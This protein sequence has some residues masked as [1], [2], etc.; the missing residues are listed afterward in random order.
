MDVGKGREHAY[1]DIGGRAMQEQLPRTRKPYFR[2][3]MVTYDLYARQLF[4]HC[5]TYSHPWLSHI[6]RAKRPYS[7]AKSK[8]AV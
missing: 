7:E 2:T 3:Q 6:F 8:H 5:S 4:L 1:R